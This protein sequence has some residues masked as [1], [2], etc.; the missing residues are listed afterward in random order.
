MTSRPLTRLPMNSWVLL[1]GGTQAVLGG[2]LQ[3]S[4]KRLK[5]AS[6]KFFIRH[7]VTVKGL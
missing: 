7:E 3:E 2:T 6:G 4:H 5:M 1:F